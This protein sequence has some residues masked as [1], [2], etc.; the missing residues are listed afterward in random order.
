VA[1]TARASFF[2][3]TGVD[4]IVALAAALSRARETLGAGRLRSSTR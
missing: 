2:V 1:G 3:H 4:D